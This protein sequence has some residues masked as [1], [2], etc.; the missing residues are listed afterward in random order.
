[1]P[2]ASPPSRPTLG[3][4][5]VHYA[6]TRKK[7]VDVSLVARALVEAERRWPG[8][9][10]DGSDR[11]RPNEGLHYMVWIT[12]G[13][14]GEFESWLDTITVLEVINDEPTPDPTKPTAIGD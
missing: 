5:K 11:Y 3:R 12:L 1:M 4:F 2:A 10:V 14:P 8:V 6:D 7:P 13:R 9:A